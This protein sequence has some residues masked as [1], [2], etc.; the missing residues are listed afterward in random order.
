VSNYRQKV[1]D[2]NH[3]EYQQDKNFIYLF[4]NHLHRNLTLFQPIFS[5]TKWQN[6]V[7]QLQGKHIDSY[8]EA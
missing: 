6:K 4:I 8:S 3:N 1:Q 7:R 2:G 5:I